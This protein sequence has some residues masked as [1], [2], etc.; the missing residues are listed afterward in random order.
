MTGDTGEAELLR[1]LRRDYLAESAERMAELQG[2]LARLRGGA[3]DAVAALKGRL[4]RLAGSGGSYGFP[5]VS[6]IAREAELWLGGGPA[7]ETIVAR[8]EEAV[9]RLEA[10]FERARTAVN[11]KQ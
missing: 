6:A 5:E 3:A 10:E 9:A 2:D 7:P 8:M 4:H 11:G 1:G